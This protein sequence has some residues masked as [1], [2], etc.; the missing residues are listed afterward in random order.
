MQATLENAFEALWESLK[1]T[2]IELPTVQH[3]FALSSI[4]PVYMTA[5]CKT[6]RMFTHDES[7][8]AGL[9]RDVCPCS[10]PQCH[11]DTLN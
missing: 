2:E 10:L 3:L 5:S 1:S 8:S 11:E 6:Q 7:H 4:L 9:C